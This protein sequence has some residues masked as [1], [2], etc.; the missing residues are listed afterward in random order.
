LDLTYTQ[1]NERA[2]LIAT[3]LIKMGVKP[4]ELVGPLRANSADWIAFYFGVLKAGAIAVT[5]SGAYGDELTNL[6]GHAKPRIIFTAESKLQELRQLKRSRRAGEDNLRQRRPGSP[7]SHGYG[8]GSFKALDRDRL[9]TAAILYTGETTGIPKVMLS[10]EGVNFSSLSI[11]YYER[12]NGKRH[13]PLL[14]SPSTMSS[15]RSIL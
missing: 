9:D 3:G 15:A 7:G 5:L 11:A 12:F 8:I 14:F 10:H 6:V 13:S 2:N 4:G 1:L